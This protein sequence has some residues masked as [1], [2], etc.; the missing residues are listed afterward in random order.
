MEQ[1]KEMKLRFKNLKYS[2]RCLGLLI[3]QHP[4]FLIGQIISLICLVVESIVPI[5][6]VSKIINA[7]EEGKTFKDI[8]IIILLNILVLIVVS[9]TNLIVSFLTNY[10]N[11]HFTLAFSTVLFK[12]VESIDYDFHENPAFLDNYTRALDDG[13]EKIFS[14]AKNQMSLIKTTFQ[15]LA[16]FSI[17]FSIHYL[18]VVYA[19]VIALIYCFT[20]RR[21]GELGFERMTDMR[22]YFRKRGYI[23]RTYFVKD[24]IPDI[25]TTDINDVMLDEHSKTLDGMKAVWKKYTVKKVLL[26]IFGSSLMVS[27]YPFILAVVC[28][29]TLGTKDLASLAA[30]TVAATSISTLV[31]T[32][33]TTITDIQ[34]DALETKIPFEVLDMTSVI[35]SDSGEVLNEDFVSLKVK[36]VSFHYTDIDKLAL[37]NINFHINKGEKIAIVGF[38]GA[39]KTTLVKL[40]LRLYDPTNGEIH[41]NDKLYTSLNVK[42][43]RKKV[44]AVFQNNEVYSVTIAENILLKKMETKEEEELVVEALKFGDIYDYVMTLPDGINTMVTREFMNQGAIFSGGQTQ[45]IAVARG[46]A[47]NYQLFILD[48]PSSALDPL[49]EAKMY[50]NM[51]ELGKERTLIFISHR[52]SATAN[53]DRIYLFENGRIVETG[54]HEQLMNIPNG[55]YKEMFDSQAEKYIGEANV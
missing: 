47:Q 16:I 10:I 40:L 4:W 8:V 12:K 53:V 38:N 51:L 23:S 46:F 22:P 44:G 9:I 18:A 29:V 14:V 36:N 19:V 42:S 1:K 32:F 39:G 35:E 50:H 5:S 26:D 3:K 15:S 13:A 17:I 54:D 43:L 52:L 55:R 31:N 25:K 33:T 2:F 6:V 21:S 7:Y 37:A 49:A 41:I 20:R 30:L 45:K 28:F 11:S 48:E 27:I 24:A 34:I